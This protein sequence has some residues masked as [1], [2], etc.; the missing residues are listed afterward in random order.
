M[1][2]CFNVLIN[3]LYWAFNLCYIYMRNKVHQQDFFKLNSVAGF[4]ISS[5]WTHCPRGP[6]I[7]KNFGLCWYISYLLDVYF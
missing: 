4:P 1:F 5:L 6:D 3:D 7:L 2:Y